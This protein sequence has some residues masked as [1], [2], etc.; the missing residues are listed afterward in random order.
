MCIKL[1]LIVN[2][3]DEP[4]RKKKLRHLSSSISFNYNKSDSPADEFANKKNP[5]STYLKTDPPKL[6]EGTTLFHEEAKYPTYSDNQPKK[7][8]K[9]KNPKYI[10]IY[11][12]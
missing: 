9:H 2:S 10:S 4:A 6:E 7:F 3:I 8:F 5:I 1:S 12:Y 11:I